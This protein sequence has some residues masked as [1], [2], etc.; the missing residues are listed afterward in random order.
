VVLHGNDNHEYSNSAFFSAEK[1]KEC[2]GSMC[3]TIERTY[4]Q[5]Y[6]NC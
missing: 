2:V 6:P 5:G 3:H 1:S 4:R